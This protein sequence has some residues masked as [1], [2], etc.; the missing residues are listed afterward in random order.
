MANNEIAAVLYGG[1][2]VHDRDGKLIQTA[3][4][5]INKVP[6]ELETGIIFHPYVNADQARSAVG[7]AGIT[8]E[9]QVVDFGEGVEYTKEGYYQLYSRAVER[10]R[11]WPSNVLAVEGH[12]F[13]IETLSRLKVP[14]FAVNQ[15]GD[16]IPDDLK[17][18][19]VFATTRPG[20]FAVVDAY[21]AE[22]A[23]VPDPVTRI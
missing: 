1:S 10:L 5:S 15:F 13:A 19:G 17:R 8:R 4:D 2:V 18:L 16:Q 14:I 21:I 3:V 7:Q 22:Y 6:P 11:T 23:K 20:S 12:I 9:L